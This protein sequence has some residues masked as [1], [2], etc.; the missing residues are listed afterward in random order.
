MV[1][2]KL[3]VWLGAL[4]V[5]AVVAPSALLAQAIPWRVVSAPVE[6]VSVAESPEAVTEQPTMVTVSPA[7]LPGPPRYEDPRGKADRLASPVLALRVWHVSSP[8]V[9]RP[10][11][12]FFAS[13]TYVSL[14][15]TAFDQ[16]VLVTSE[17]LV[18]HAPKL[19][20]VRDGREIEVE[21]HWADP[22]HGL[23]ILSIDPVALRGLSPAPLSQEKVV[24]SVW[25]AARDEGGGAAVVQRELGGRGEGAL[26]YYTRF[27][28]ALGIGAPLLDP[29]GG[30]WGITGLV[31]IEGEGEGWAINVDQIR[32]FLMASLEGDQDNVVTETVVLDVGPRPRRPVESTP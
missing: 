29:K 4:G 17:F 18:R 7:D 14:P 22:D 32:T 26:E 19:A 8:Y 12:S 11:D 3:A 16:G 30:L 15:G 24:A 9:V 25:L 23:A 6:E 27:D 31:G 28:S 5:S 1:W 13:V 10:Q 2:P 21:V 20:V